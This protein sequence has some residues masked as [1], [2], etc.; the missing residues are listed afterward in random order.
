MKSV[1]PLRSCHLGV[2]LHEVPAR[3]RRHPED[4]LLDV[5]VAGFEFLLDQLA[6]IG[7]EVVVVRR[8]DKGGLQLGA[9]LLE[10]VGDVLQEDQAQHDVHVVAGVDIG[11][12]AVGR[13]PQTLVEVVEE[14]LFFA[15]HS[16]PATTG[17][18]GLSRQR[19]WI[20]WVNLPIDRS[21]P[22]L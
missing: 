21:R 5:V 22:R 10:G 17:S 7:A 8:V 9:A 18:L 16:S 13:V 12:Q 15:I 4:V 3:E 14:L 6:R 11:A 2:G 20:R 19:L 1:F